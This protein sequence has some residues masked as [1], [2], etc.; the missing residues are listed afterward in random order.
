MLGMF[1][2][3]IELSYFRICRH[4]WHLHCVM[5]V[6][7]K[8]PVTQKYVHYIMLSSSCESGYCSTLHIRMS[9]VI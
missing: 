1:N 3:I 5:F 4:Y 9:S 8:Q 2:I 7:D 6:L